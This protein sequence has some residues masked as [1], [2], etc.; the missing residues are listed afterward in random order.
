MPS[1]SGLRDLQERSSPTHDVIHLWLNKIDNQ[2]KVIGRITG[3]NTDFSRHQI[4]SK[5][6]EVPIYGYRNFLLGI[7]D[8]IITAK[9]MVY[10]PSNTDNEFFYFVPPAGVDRWNCRIMIDFLVEIKSQLDSIS[11][12][13]GQIKAYRNA[14]EQESNGRLKSVL[15]T[16]DDQSTKFDDLLKTEG[17]SVFRIPRQEINELLEK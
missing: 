14:Y 5:K 2:E 17:I 3:Q 4:D 11:A 10:F 6:T 15:L 9:V 16:I 8:C 7:I 12:T 1:P 13:I